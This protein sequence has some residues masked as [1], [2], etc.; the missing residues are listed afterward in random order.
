MELLDKHSLAEIKLVGSTRVGML[1]VMAPEISPL[2]MAMDKEGDRLKV[3]I[4]ISSRTQRT[5]AFYFHHL[6]YN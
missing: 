4:A 5:F 6:L 1:P 3:R 2:H